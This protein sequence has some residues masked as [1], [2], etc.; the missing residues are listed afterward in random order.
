MANK[1]T[2][3][4]FARIAAKAADEAGAT[5]HPPSRQVRC[6]GGRRFKGAEPSCE[7]ALV[8]ARRHSGQEPTRTAAIPCFSSRDIGIESSDIHQLILIHLAQMHVCVFDS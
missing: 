6:G 4:N 3:I 5:R 7:F 8:S 1:R 2:G